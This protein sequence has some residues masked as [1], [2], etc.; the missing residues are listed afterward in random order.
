MVSVFT[1]WKCLLVYG[2]KLIS[3]NQSCLWKLGEHWLKDALW[4]SCG[5]LR[6]FSLKNIS[7][8]KKVA[9]FTPA[10]L[11]CSQVFFNRFWPEVQ[12]NHIFRTAFCTF[13]E[14]HSRADYET[15]TH[16]SVKWCF[17]LYKNTSCALFFACGVSYSIWRWSS[18]NSKRIK[19]WQSIE[20]FPKNV[21]WR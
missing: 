1:E 16:N 8:G 7:E 9:G 10:A 19:V 3:R 20:R 6:F 12:K 2:L 17:F 15:A 11:H 5:C 18:Q 13:A 14:F 21:A 4:N